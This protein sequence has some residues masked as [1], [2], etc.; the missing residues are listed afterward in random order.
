MY[1]RELFGLIKDCQL[2]DSIALHWLLNTCL[3]KLQLYVIM[4]LVNWLKLQI[5]K[6][7]EQGK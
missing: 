5:K 6:Q 2:H 3:S 7:A 1:P 4:N